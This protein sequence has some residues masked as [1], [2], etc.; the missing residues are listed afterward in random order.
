M[1]M[2][3]A[4]LRRGSVKKTTSVRRPTSGG[5]QKREKREIV[6]M[7]E[8]LDNLGQFEIVS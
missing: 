2:D 5:A 7:V 3:A 4:P 6:K 1:T 8:L